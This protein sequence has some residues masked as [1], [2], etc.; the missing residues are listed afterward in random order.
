ME[1]RFHA[2][3]LLHER[4]LPM[5]EPHTLLTGL[6]FGES[7]RWH[8]G[9]LWVADWGAQEVLAVDLEGN[10]EV[11]VRV[12]FP[13]F[14]MG[15]DWL[16][17]GRLLIV[18]PSEG[19]LLRREPDGSLTPYADLTGLSAHPWN[20]V[21]VDGRGNAY[22]NNIGFEFPGGE[23]APGSV[24]LVTPDGAAR[25]VAEGIAFPNGMVVTPDNATLIVAESYAAKLTAY[26][27]AADGGLS[28]GRVWAERQGG[29]RDGICR[30]AEGAVWCSDVP[31]RR[32]LRVRQ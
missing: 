30:D 4:S 1:R 26:E 9:R 21:V 16:P 6:A 31:N 12:S 3:R 2:L 19:L 29:V 10:K 28:R 25:K 18:S 7:P 11:V 27:I 20:E 13:S 24:A 22:V 8:D 5:P 14:P 32:C 23:F 15:I 17:D